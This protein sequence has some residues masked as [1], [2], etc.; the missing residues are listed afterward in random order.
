[1]RLLP[2]VLLASIASFCAFGQDYVITTVAGNG[3]F[4]FSGDNGP[5][6]SAQLSARR[7]RFHGPE[8]LGPGRSPA[9]VLDVVWSKKADRIEIKGS[10]RPFAGTSSTMIHSP[11]CPKPSIHFGSCLFRSPA[12]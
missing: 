3:T 2:A 9:L 4:G 6:T 7:P 11:R 1:M 12:G 10:Q 8:S 5:A